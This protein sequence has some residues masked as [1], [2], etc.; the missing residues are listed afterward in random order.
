MGKFFIYNK[1]RNLIIKRSLIAEKYIKESFYLDLVIF[2]C[3][4]LV[5]LS[6]NNIQF[7]DL[8]IILKFKLVLL[9]KFNI[10][11]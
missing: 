10:C 3:F 6:V 7:I 9:K 2:I 8:L 1:I 4:T 5:K 11:S